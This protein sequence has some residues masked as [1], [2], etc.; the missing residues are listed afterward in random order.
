MARLSSDAQK[1]LENLAQ[2]YSLKQMPQSQRDKFFEL[3]KKSLL[4]SDL[5]KWSDYMDAIKGNTVP[6]ELN[7]SKISDANDKKEIYERLQDWFQTLSEDEDLKSDSAVTNFISKYNSTVGQYRFKGFD[8]HAKEIATAIETNLND[9]SQV[10]GI[11]EKDLKTLAKGLDDGTYKTNIKTHEICSTF[12]SKL[13]NL[14]YLS[15]GEKLIPLLPVFLQEDSLNREAFDKLS[16][17]L[18]KSGMIPSK[19]ASEIANALDGHENDY[20]AKMGM[21]KTKLQNLKEALR[22]GSYKSDDTKKQLLAQFLLD[23]QTLGDSEYADLKDYI[24]T[25]LKSNGVN[26]YVL[27][28]LVTNNDDRVSN[29]PSTTRLDKPLQEMFEQLASNKKLRDKVLPHA[30][31]INTFYNKGAEKANYNEGK[32]K[33]DHKFSYRKNAFQRAKDKVDNYLTETVGK[34]ASKHNRH[35]YQCP[36]AKDMVGALIN[37]KGVKAT[38]GMGKLLDSMKSVQNSVAPGTKEKIDWG[39]KELEKISNV[40]YFKDALRNGRDMRQMVQQIVLDAVHEEKKDEAKVLLETLAVMRYSAVS[41]SVRDDLRKAEFKIFSGTSLAKENAFMGN[42]MG[43]LDKTLR[44]AALGVFEI[45]NMAK[46]AY[47]SSGK[48]ITGQ[49][50]EKGVKESNEY[51]D[52][53]THDAMAELFE[54]WNLANGTESKTFN[55][56]RRKSK[57][58][59]PDLTAYMNAHS[60]RFP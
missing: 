5:E 57:A 32:T 14:E 42:M 44:F 59:A 4:S 28:N 46:N 25:S 30:G 56:F 41:S 6:A 36:E 48:K 16:E 13:S 34:L 21:E 26:Q 54:F 24:P 20:S 40:G 9:Y 10:L 7:F 3:H 60:Q 50:L 8:A 38:D 53:A 43:A 51:K 39:I 15:N 18:S 11:P 23:M 49:N 47:K 17:E 29:P 35:N 12:L 45:A 52:T 27:Y 19:A 37:K 22:D 58:T 2:F 31:D 1:F 33:L 55:I